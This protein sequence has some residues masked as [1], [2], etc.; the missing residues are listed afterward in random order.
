MDSKEALEDLEQK[1]KKSATEA[2]QRIQTIQ[3][4]QDAAQA[5]LNYQRVRHMSKEDFIHWKAEESEVL[6]PPQPK[7]LEGVAP[8][9]NK[10]RPIGKE[11]T[12]EAEEKRLRVPTEVK[13]EAPAPA[14]NGGG[15]KPS[16]QAY[17]TCHPWKQ[18][19]RGYTDH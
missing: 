4:R 2:H 15:I 11:A 9:A 5:R 17:Q 8:K 7:A 13:A 1:K 18:Y 19:P 16:S 14:Q 12:G 10:K 3:E 6:T